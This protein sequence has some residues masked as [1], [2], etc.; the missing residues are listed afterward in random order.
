M[1]LWVC[2]SICGGSL[3]LLDCKGCFFLSCIQSINNKAGSMGI[4]IGLVEIRSHDILAE[5]VEMNYIIN[6]E[7]IFWS[8]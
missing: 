8:Y 5:T 2:I 4:V 6:N 1:D 7:R 3:L